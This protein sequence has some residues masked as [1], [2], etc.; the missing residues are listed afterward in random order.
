MQTACSVGVSR[1]APRCT[2]ANPAGEHL[3][4]A[5]HLTHVLGLGNLLA[6]D[7]LF[8]PTAT[9][10]SALRQRDRRLDNPCSELACGEIGFKAACCMPHELQH[11]PHV[12]MWPHARGMHMHGT[13]CSLS[14]CYLASFPGRQ[15]KTVYGR[16][17]MWQVLPNSICGRAAVHGQHTARSPVLLL[18]RSRTCAS[19]DLAPRN[20]LCNL[21]VAF[22]R[23]DWVP[24][25]TRTQSACRCA[26]I[27]LRRGRGTG[28]APCLRSAS[29]VGSPEA[30]LK[31][32]SKRQIAIDGTPVASAT[33]RN[34][35][36]LADVCCC[37]PTPPSARRAAGR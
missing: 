5:A 26:P 24:S 32:Q 35:T 22:S 16:P 21:P 19:G 7:R 34:G 23:K 10:Q 13:T 8:I 6:D 12:M 2:H 1:S 33:R 3:G 9:N 27:R 37:A 14:F 36:L 31:H 4:C 11:C 30:T 17:D 18:Q 29:R 28:D 20:L 15:R 25:T